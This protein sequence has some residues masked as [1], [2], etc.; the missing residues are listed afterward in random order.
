MK[1]SRLTLF[2]LVVVLVVIG[3]GT[4]LASRNA[5]GVTAIDTTDQPTIGDP[6]ASVRVVVFEEPRCSDCKDYHQTVFPLLREEFINTKKIIYTVIPIAFLPHSMPGAVALLCV[7][8]QDPGFPNGDLFMRFLDNL[9]RSNW[10]T[11]EQILEIAAQTSTCIDLSKLQ[12]CIN[13][14]TYEK[15]IAANLALAHGLQ[16]ESFSVPSLYVNGQRVIPTDYEHI[17]AAILKEIRP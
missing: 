8:N 5:S 11:Q 12:N 7:Y 2:V 14:A 15:Q 4:W 3:G 10:E 13:Q 16:K 9:L 1:L 6:H 17:R